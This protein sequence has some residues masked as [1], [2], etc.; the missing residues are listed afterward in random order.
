MS[1]Q[2][3]EF[4]DH[5]QL[6]SAVT[7]E[8]A[9]QSLFSDDVPPAG[10]PC[11]WCGSFGHWC[12][13]K[14]LFVGDGVMPEA[15]V[16]IAC[17]EGRDC[18]VVAARLKT[19]EQVLSRFNAPAGVVRN[20]TPA[21]P[22]KRVVVEK[23][24][25]RR[26][27]SGRELGASAKAVP[28]QGMSRRERYE[29]IV[30]RPKPEVA[31][32]VVREVKAPALVP[33]PKAEEAMP[34]VVALTEEIKEKIRTADPAEAAAALAKR[35]NIKPHLV[36]YWRERFAVIAARTTKP[37]AKQTKLAK[38]PHRG[39]SIDI[40]GVSERIHAMAEPAAPVPETIEAN[41][42]ITVNTSRLDAWWQA[43]PAATKAEI[44]LASIGA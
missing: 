16:C 2:L 25:V 9:E 24:E 7:R 5:A 18:S 38:T 36:Y 39:V 37:A 26:S 21:D 12:Q 10:T 35:L 14:R 8:E 43:L 28:L 33:A 6:A 1:D 40:V 4:G 31:S 32:I 22:A 44:A 20:V 23:P 13:A 30:E 17:S 3:F 42:S 15:P 29:P 34:Q 19:E 11:A 41:V 27:V